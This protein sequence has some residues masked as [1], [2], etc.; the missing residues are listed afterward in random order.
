[1]PIWI[2][3]SDL[4][5]ACL[6]HAVVARLDPLAPDLFLLFE[7]LTV[8]RVAEECPPSA[9]SI[10]NPCYAHAHT[11]GRAGRCPAADERDAPGLRTIKTLI[12]IRSSVDR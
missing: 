12:T 8:D 6:D 5:E 3:A 11:N 7:R 10:S 2:V 1:M 9:G 4:V